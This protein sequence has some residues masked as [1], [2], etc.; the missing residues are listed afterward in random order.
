MGAITQ[1]RLDELIEIEKKLLR[2]KEYLGNLSKDDK[3]NNVAT[4]KNTLKMILE[5]V[6]KKGLEKAIHELGVPPFWIDEIVKNRKELEQG[7]KL[8]LVQQ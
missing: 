4:K 5:L 8:V 7:F 6:D 1:G 3:G 2:C